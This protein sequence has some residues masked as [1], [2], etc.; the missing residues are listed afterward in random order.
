M[1]TSQI[2]GYNVFADDLDQISL[3]RKTIINTVN[4]YSYVLAKSDID[5]N[6]ALKLSDVLLPDGFPIVLANSILNGTSISKVAGEDVF[7]HLFS[8]M[9]ILGGKIFFLGASVRT[10]EKICH[11]AKVDFPN[12]KVD[13]FSP[14]YKVLFSKED[15]DSM[16][17]AVNDF[18]PDVL[19]VGMT[20]P[21]QEKWVAQHSANLNATIIC[22]IGAVFDFYAGTIKRP[23]KFWIKLRLEWFVRFLKEPKRLWKRYFWY[24]PQ[25]FNDILKEKFFNRSKH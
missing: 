17:K 20:A 14:P 5:F 16:I 11:R 7:Y 24:S 3:H 1:K 13:C 2:L 10:L 6:K 12:V 9:N 23:S 25:L 8:K 18:M 19:F 4:A 22:S 15:S 21:K